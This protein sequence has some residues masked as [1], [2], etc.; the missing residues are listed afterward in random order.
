MGRG[1]LRRRAGTRQPASIVSIYCEGD[2]EEQYFCQVRA[3]LRAPNFHVETVSP[4]PLNI[5]EYAVEFSTGKG[6]RFPGDEVWCVFDVEAPKPH[7]RLDEA[8]RLADRNDISCAISHPCFEVWPLLHLV[9]HHAHIAKSDDA[10]ELL[11]RVL[12][13]YTRRRKFIDYGYIKAG[14]EE[15]RERAIKLEAMHGESVRLRD[16][17]PS[18]SVWRLMEAIDRR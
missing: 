14:Y 8:I 5:V 15:A 10:G 13:G 3:D 11:E 7:A 17:N 9:D 2:T 16:R 6:N 12:P 4:D 18:T 1:N